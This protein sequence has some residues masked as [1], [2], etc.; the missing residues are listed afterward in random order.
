MVT[1]GDYNPTEYSE[2]RLNLNTEEYCGALETII[3]Y[4]LINFAGK[5]ICFIIPHK[6]KNQG[7][8]GNGVTFADFRKK[9]IGLFEKYAVPY[10]DAWAE[11]GLNNWDKTQLDNYFI[12][13][14]NNT[15][16]DGTHPNTEGY[17]RYYVPQLISL[18]ERIMPRV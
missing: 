3:R 6:C 13:H 7:D 2:E 8:Y 10:Y 4:S 16:G 11:S 1:L 15:T 9:I 14:G 5:P 12:I 18:F 17:K